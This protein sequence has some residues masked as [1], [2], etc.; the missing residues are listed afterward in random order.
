MALV[1]GEILRKASVLYER[2]AGEIR[3]EHVDS[4]SVIILV[5]S[6]INTGQMVVDFIRRLTRLNAALRIVIIAAVVQDEE[7]ANIEALKNTIQRQQ[8]GLRTKQQIY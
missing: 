4:K 6:V 1:V 7:I 3:I 5:D 8:V 2:H